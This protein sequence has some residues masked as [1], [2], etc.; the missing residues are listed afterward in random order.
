MNGCHLDYFPMNIGL[1]C[2]H[3]NWLIFFRTGWRTTTNRT[4]LLLIKNHPLT[5]FLVD[6]PPG[7]WMTKHCDFFDTMIIVTLSTMT[8]WWF[9]TFFIFPY[10]GNNHPSWLIFFRG[11]AQPP[12]R[13][14][15]S[16]LLFLWLLS[17]CD[18]DKVYHMKNRV[19]HPVEYLG[20]SF[21]LVML[22]CCS[23][24]ITKI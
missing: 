19:S 16:W 1:E 4:W 22:L 11:V 20:V 5:G 7:D 17:Y 3:P 9:G 18:Y 8:G 13:W 15:L 14:W 2:H 12:T 23:T 10:I 21:R 24:N 6:K